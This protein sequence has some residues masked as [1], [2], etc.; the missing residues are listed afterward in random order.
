MT[1]ERVDVNRGYEPG[2]CKWADLEEQSRNKRTNRLIEHE[3]I[4]LCVKDW[5]K[6]VGINGDTIRA[7]LRLGWDVGLALTTPVRQTK[8]GEGWR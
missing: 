3:G 7:R 8:K 5:G 1:I 6:R 4:S 2:N